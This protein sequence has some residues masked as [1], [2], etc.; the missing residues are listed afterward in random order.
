MWCKGLNDVFCVLVREYP[1][2]GNHIGCTRKIMLTN[3][4]YGLS[5]RAFESLFFQE[6]KVKSD[7]REWLAASLPL[8]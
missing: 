4:A 7:V 5:S 6:T 1:A 3:P 2:S 8:H